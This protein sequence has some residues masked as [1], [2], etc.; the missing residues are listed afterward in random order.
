MDCDANRRAKRRGLREAF[1]VNALTENHVLTS[2]E[3]A[4]RPF[5]S[6]DKK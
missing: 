1:R 4:V 6:E 2:A 3:D 5:A